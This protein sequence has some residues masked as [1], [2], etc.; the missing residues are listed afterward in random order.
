MGVLACALFISLSTVL[1]KLVRDRG[2]VY[3]YDSH[4][5]STLCYCASAA[6]GHS[7][8]SLCMSVAWVV[9]GMISMGVGG[10]VGWGVGG[11]LRYPSVL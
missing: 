8:V 11:R 9:R 6:L 3:V 4:P 5:W 1:C 7:H 2:S 10:G